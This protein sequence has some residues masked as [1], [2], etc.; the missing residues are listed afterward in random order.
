MKIG[1]RVF[2]LAASLMTM[3]TCTP[4]SLRKVTYNILPF[5]SPP[6]SIVVCE[7]TKVLQLGLQ[8]RHLAQTAPPVVTLNWHD[9]ISEVNGL[10]QKQRVE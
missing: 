3:S 2:P 4:Y 8:I 7:M 6:I 5:R 10:V 1:T 9:G